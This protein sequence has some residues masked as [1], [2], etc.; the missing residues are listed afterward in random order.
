MSL[1]EV[2]RLFEE[3][4]LTAMTM[5]TPVVPVYVD[6]QI[7]PDSGAAKE[8]AVVRVDFGLTT[9][10]SLAENFEHLRGVV[11]VEIYTPKGQGPGRAQELATLAAKALNGIND[12]GPHPPTG[13]YGHVRGMEGPSFFPL[14]DT[15][16]YLARL[17]C[18]FRATYN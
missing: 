11:T 14:S 6:N 9:E 16:H 15:P 18:S 17:S 1:Q 12:C 5:T 10:E 7:F 13:A 4:V 2:R 8:H 3:P